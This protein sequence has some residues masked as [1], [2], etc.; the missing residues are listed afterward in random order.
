MAVCV[1][2]LA[3]GAAVSAA[4]RV[5]E[6]AASAMTAVRLDGVEQRLCDAGELIESHGH[7][8]FG[9]EGPSAKT[10]EGAVDE[11]LQELRIAASA[12]NPQL[13]ELPERDRVALSAWL[14]EYL[15]P[16]R[17]LS[18]AKAVEVDGFSQFERSMDDGS[19]RLDAFV[20]VE[21]H[22]N[23]GFFVAEAHFCQSAVMRS[24]ALEAFPAV[25][26]KED[27]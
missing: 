18:V 1:A 20:T 16:M 17:S 15:A 13:R 23:G 2:G 10:A 19:G 7:P 12:D 22:D 6:P 14:E 3:M 5:S 11:F 27:Q 26:G 4:V 24:G 21:Q 8:E 25:I 9:D